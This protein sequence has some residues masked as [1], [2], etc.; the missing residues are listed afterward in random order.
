MLQQG[1][2]LPELLREANH[3]KALKRASEM[4]AMFELVDTEEIA[5]SAGLRIATHEFI[6]QPDR[7]TVKV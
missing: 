2:Q 6:S 7:N 1:A 3:P 5:P 4:E